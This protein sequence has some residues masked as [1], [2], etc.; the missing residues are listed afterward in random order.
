MERFILDHSKWAVVGATAATG[1]VLRN[2]A[3][4]T[5][6]AGAVV[7]MV[8]ARV[9]KRLINQQRPKEAA[10]KSSEG[11]PSSHACNLT[12]YACQL[13]LV[14]GWGTPPAVAV[15][16]AWAVLLAYRVAYRY[17]TKSQVAAGIVLGALLTLGW[18]RF[19]EAVQLNALVVNL[20]N[21]TLG[22]T[23][24]FH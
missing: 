11:M 15:Q 18:N 5:F 9:L 7:A 12:Y 14:F 4:V 22:Y 10:W 8:V 3:S 23:L 19:V 21:Q 13:T 16:L 17:H 2:G 6:V 24:L 1:L 20:V